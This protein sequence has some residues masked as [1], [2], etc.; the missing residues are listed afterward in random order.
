MEEQPPVPVQGE[1]YGPSGCLAPGCSAPP[2]GTLQAPLPL[3]FPVRCRCRGPAVL[4]LW[5]VR[6]PRSHSAGVFAPSLCP[7]VFPKSRTL[8]G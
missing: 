8:I 1:Q 5:W 6:L 7:I 2:F 4:C 3:G